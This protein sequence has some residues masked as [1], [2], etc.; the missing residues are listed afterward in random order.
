MIIKE[1]KQAHTLTHSQFGLNVIT[2]R[3][4]EF[5]GLKRIAQIYTCTHSFF[6]FFTFSYLFASNEHAHPSVSHLRNCI[7]IILHFD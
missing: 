2:H 5:A 4:I 3:I 1:E 7:W 6:L